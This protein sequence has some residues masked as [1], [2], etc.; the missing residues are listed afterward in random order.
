MGLGNLAIK[1]LTFCPP[2]SRRLLAWY[3][4]AGLPLPAAA[5]WVVANLKRSLVPAGNSLRQVQIGPRLSLLVDLR[6]DVGRE[7]FYHRSY[8]PHVARFL[9]ESLRPG[10]VV[11]DCGANIGELSLRAAA[12]V[13]PAGRVYAVEASPPT[14]S[15]LRQ[16]VGRNQADN[17]E[18]VE[19]AVTDAD[20]E[21][22]FFL[23]T[24]LHSLSSSLWQPADFHGEQV[25]VR[26]TTLTTLLMKK[27]ITRL[28][29][30]KLDIEGAELKALRGAE[31][32]FRRLEKLPM[33]VFEYN[34][35]V[36]D[37][38]GWTLTDMA[39]LLL[40]WG[41]TI[42]YLDAGRP[43]RSYRAEDAAG[44]DESTKIDLVCLP[45]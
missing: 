1:T 33:L 27:N 30:V 15:L 44:F 4:R 9:T 34:K 8:E 26:G 22:A 37:R 6:T 7:I 35:G 11:I 42:R 24:E 40:S 31:A 25:A 41:Y 10:G 28:D 43:G 20:T 16:N 32:G 3:L 12:A 39:D 45:N 5:A 2:V 21:Q 38:A 14:A 23:G 36:A 13:G 29:L 17:V 19:A 18:V